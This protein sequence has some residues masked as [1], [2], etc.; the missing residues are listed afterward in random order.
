MALK[1]QITPSRRTPPAPGRGVPGAGSVRGRGRE[2]HPYRHQ[3]D[4]S[5]RRRRE[6]RRSPAEDRDQGC[7]E[8]RGEDA[9][10]RVGTHD[11]PVGG[12]PLVRRGPFD[13]D[14]QRGGREDAFGGAER[15]PHEKQDG[16]RPGET[17]QRG[18]HRPGQQG[19]ERDPPRTV[20]VGEQPAGYLGEGVGEEEGGD[21]QALL[22][23]AEVELGTERGQD[24]IDDE[25]VGVVD[26]PGGEQ[27]DDRDPDGSPGGLRGRSRHAALLITVAETGHRPEVPL[28]SGL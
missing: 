3:D 25:P 20:P 26:Q 13:E 2:P 9:G 7:D 21:D 14:L 18:E 23:A 16:E 11:Q 4:D 27:Q 12:H 5:E 19:P 1:R 24:Q 6:E 15:E 8:E 22:P 10:D 17:G 28:P